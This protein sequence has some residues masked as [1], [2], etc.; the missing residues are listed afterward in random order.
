[1]TYV[2]LQVISSYSL[3]KST[4]SISS[5]IDQAKKKGYKALALT[6]F[7]VLY[8]AVEFYEKAKENNIKPILGMTVEVDA[9]E[10]VSLPLEM[11][12]LAKNKTGYQSL[13]TLSTD[14][15]LNKANLSLNSIE[16]VQQ[17]IA[18]VLP[19]SEQEELWKLLVGRDR[20]AVS[21]LENCTTLFDDFYVGIKW[22]EDNN[23]ELVKV[24]ELLESL[25]IDYLINEPVYYLHADDEPAL[26]VLNAIENQE[27]LDFE[28][29]SARQTNYCLKDSRE[30]ENFYNDKQLSRGVE[31]TAE[32][33]D[34]ISIEFSWASVLPEFPKPEGM[35]SEKYLE[36]V[37]YKWLNKKIEN[38]SEAYTRR[39][40]KELSVI[41]K[42]GF[43][44]YF[45]IVWDLMAYAHK[46]NIVT[47]AGRG[48]A[49]GSLVS[50]VLRIT[51]VD[52]IEYDLLFDR[53]LNE[54]RFT[55]PDIDLDF[56]DDKREMILNYVF[57]K[58]G[59]DHVA[60]IAT[61]G[62][63]AA[64]MAVRDAGRTLGLSTEEL[65]RWS[66]AIPSQPGITLKEAYHS[67]QELKNLLTES[68]LH[69]QIF[70]IAV[71][72]EGL[73]RHVSTHAAG[74]VIS[75]NNLTELTPLQEGS[76]VMPLT[77]YTMGDV[78]KVGLLKMDFL[79]LK[80]LTILA[81]C[82]RYTKELKGTIEEKLDS[83]S[84]SDSQTI[85]L[86]KKGHTNGIF[87]FE[88]PGI[89]RVLK[90]L[91]PDTFEDIVAVNALYRPGPME[92]IDTFI[93]RK[94]GTE[95]IHYLH[96]DLEDILSV[97]N[98]II[99]YQEQVMK[100][101]SKIAGY[102]LSEADILRRAISKKIKKEIDAGR[103]QFVAG[104]K[105]K[106]YAEETAT[107]IY[108]L[109]ERFANYGFNRSHA[110]SY[111]K[112]AF[113]LAYFKVH[114]PASFYVSL[115]RE[116][117]NNKEKVKT[118]ILEAKKQSIKIKPPSI[119]ESQGSFTV[120]E[121][122]IVFGL[123][124]VKGLRK[125]FIRDILSERKRNGHYTDLI[126]LVSRLDQRWR[127]S[128]LI[129]PLIHSGSLDGFADNRNTMLHSI[130]PVL[131]SIAMSNGNIELFESLAP[132]TEVQPPLS[133]KDKLRQEFEST[134]FYLSGHPTEQFTGRANQFL[135]ESNNN[136]VADY[137]VQ[138]EAIKKIQTKRGEPMAFV[139]VSDSSGEATAVLFPENYR[140]FSKYCIEES[141][142]SV[143]GKAEW[144]KDQLN[145]LV[146][147]IKEVS[148]KSE[149][150]RRLFLKIDQLASSQQKLKD[151]L[152][153]LQSYP[154][155]VPVIV[156]DSVAKRK[157][158]LK[159]QYF[160]D[161]S[162]ECLDE[163]A[164]LLGKKNVILKDKRN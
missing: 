29:I 26:K 103:N 96:P 61:F 52:P 128:S 97:T 50:Y 13:M 82:L 56:P 145:I 113:Q 151:T 35:S 30:V 38:P 15:M 12:L 92:Q 66:A 60:Q 49:A 42:M 114:F 142:I 85:N 94:N 139:T 72:L 46:Q 31:K 109:I 8:G 115:L 93:A 28:T 65:K 39:L 76:G 95:T 40:A 105:R 87:Q 152:S 22:T 88:S 18:A 64:K 43:A 163:L 158:T 161:P 144:K 23:E 110:V 83:I 3:L 10:A 149:E 124:S 4:V 2:P 36:D 121:G 32:L 47:G 119:N 101:A 131:D 160:T 159:E 63:F 123:D 48:S 73:P 129:V 112:L 27:K 62:T 140:K 86:F 58:Y 157:E 51:D 20:N 54:E 89:K 55:L 1:M 80:N 156:Y 116:S 33:A 71:K 150:Q 135:M 79:G 100:V 130:E 91:G 102:S 111:S 6:D 24:L 164:Q 125:D 162:V 132:R 17:D 143:N 14:K 9:V 137:V 155:T 146:N 147:A 70:S 117:T 153:T 44:D 136:G 138:V 57:N 74:V 7:N 106:G 104:A 90:K 68:E 122:A 118:Y 154:G 34:K 19:I 99:V 59:K 133:S 67:S 98:G 126:N 25:N 11:V 107:E 141:V 127:K 108:D 120:S 45:L 148:E 16:A 5:L 84:L 81:N 134:G 41:N 21:L 75:R 37:A 53:F 77:Q 78:E 69:K